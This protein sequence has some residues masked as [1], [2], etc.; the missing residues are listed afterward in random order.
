MLVQGTKGK[1]ENVSAIPVQ[2]LI[3]LHLTVDLHGR[4]KARTRR[5]DMCAP[6][7]IAIQQRDHALRLRRGRHITAYAHVALQ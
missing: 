3:N 6:W 1:Y 4:G 5:I 2:H 7:H